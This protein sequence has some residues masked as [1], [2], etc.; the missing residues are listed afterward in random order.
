MTI[1]IS[2]PCAVV[3]AWISWSVSGRDNVT[4]S[5]PPVAQRRQ[6]GVRA[7]AGDGHHRNIAL[8]TPCLGDAREHITDG[9]GTDD[10]DL[11]GWQGERHTAEDS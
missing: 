7:G 4:K 2:G 11:G 6:G 8:L 10:G 9:G 1:E 3:Y 5:R